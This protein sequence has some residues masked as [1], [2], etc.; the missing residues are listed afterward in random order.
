[1]RVLKT[2]ITHAFLG[3]GL[4][5]AVIASSGCSKD[6]VCL[7][8]QLAD[9][10]VDTFEMSQVEFQGSEGVYEFSNLV[11]NSLTEEFCT[12]V[13]SAPESDF[14][15][16][17][18]YSENGSFT[19][20][21]LVLN[22][23]TRIDS[24]S[25]SEGYQSTLGV[26]FTSNGYYRYMTGVDANE[27]VDERDEFNNDDTRNLFRSPTNATATVHITGLDPASANGTEETVKLLYKR[28]HKIEV[29]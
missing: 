16:S 20:P 21:E 23:Y 24:L 1:M 5:F 15:T 19:D 9:L 10:L 25:V 4:L 14:R 28:G 12:N 2:K 26:V 18:F 17:I 3:V 29:K 22:D 11:V 7:V 13:K 8:L 6:D 27:Q